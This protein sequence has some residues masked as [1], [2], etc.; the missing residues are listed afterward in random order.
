MAVGR[1]ISL[2]ARQTET[3]PP[4][5]P[6]GGG[7]VHPFSDVPAWLLDAVTWG[8]CNSYMAGYGDGTF[9]P[10]GAIT[11][12]QVARLLYRVAGSPSVA[13]LPAHGLSDV[14]LWVEDAVTWLVAN[15]HMTGYPDGKF[16]PN[17]PI[18]RGQVTRVTY[19]VKGSPPGSPPHPFGDV[20]AW[21][22]A[23]VNWAA[24][25]PDGAGPLPALMNGYP[26]NLFRPDADITRGQT[27]RL[28]CRANATPGTC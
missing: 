8:Y 3:K 23:S 5:G 11:R 14:P 24:H 21:L 1:A 17:V 10:N 12:A 13:G 9:R 22:V 18:S 15:S 2:A 16:R 20:P 4:T 6:R 27:T 26:G 25:D 7:C 19:R 28:T